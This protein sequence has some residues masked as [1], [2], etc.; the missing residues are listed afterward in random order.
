MKTVPCRVI[1]NGSAAETL[2]ILLN[3]DTARV[4]GADWLTGWALANKTVRSDL[5]E[6]YPRRAKTIERAVEVYGEARLVELGKGDAKLSDGTLLSSY[7]PAKAVVVH[8]VIT[9]LEKGTAK[10]PTLRQTGE[11]LLLKGAHRLAQA[12]LAND[13]LGNVKTCNKLANALRKGKFLAADK[14]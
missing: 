6:L 7:D 14:W 3:A 12:W 11:A 8:R 9:R 4:T 2:F 1:D 13:K 10:L 5:F